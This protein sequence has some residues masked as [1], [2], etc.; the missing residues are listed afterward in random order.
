MASPQ[1]IATLVIANGAQDSNS[2]TRDQFGNC[3]SLSFICQE[4][5]L[6]G[7]VTVE[8]GNAYPDPTNW[9]TLQSPPGTDVAIAAD[10]CVP[11][12]AV[13]FPALR[14]HSASA[15]GAARTFEVWGEVG[16]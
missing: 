2:I 15:E 6:T 8:V 7:V 3:R 9:A 14:L 12:T 13:P 1:K 11:I 10:K 16:E 4:A 5:A